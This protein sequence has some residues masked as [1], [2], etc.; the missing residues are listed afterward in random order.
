MD[1]N[2]RIIGIISIIVLIIL[3][4]VLNM[5]S[6]VKQGY[7][8]IFMVIIPLL[9]IYLY[10]KSN[11]KDEYNIKNVTLQDLKVPLYYGIGIF[12][13]G[14]IG[15]LILKPIVDSNTL[16]GGLQE[17]GITLQNIY[18]S[19]LYISFINSFIEEFFFRGFIFQ[20]FKKINLATGYIVSSLLFSI[21]HVLVMFA[22]FNVIMGFLAMVGL[23]LVGL[24]LVYINRTNKSIINSWIVHIFADL[25]VCSIGIYWFIMMAA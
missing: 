2:I 18:L 19:V 21:Y 7:K 4:Q 5:N 12:F 10:K 20:H 14:I 9:V 24:F 17:R 8:M 16:V 15:Y 23:T 13:L 11:F 22:I 6:F 3:E 25:G 1:R